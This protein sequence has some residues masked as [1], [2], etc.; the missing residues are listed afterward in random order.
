MLPI[1]LLSP[2]CQKPPS[3]RIEIARFSPPPSNA[4]FDESLKSRDARWGVRDLERDI[5]PMTDKAGLTLEAVVAM[6][7]NNFSVVFSR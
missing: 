2:L 5:V 4:A 6:P 1:E 7:A 3:P